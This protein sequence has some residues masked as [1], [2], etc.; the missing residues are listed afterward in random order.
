MAPDKGIRC[1]GMILAL[2]GAWVGNASGA[3]PEGLPLAYI[4]DHQSGFTA[5]FPSAMAVDL[6]GRLWVSSD[7]GGLFGAMASAF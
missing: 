2:I 6:Q 4:L 1:L 5:S 7:L 3:A